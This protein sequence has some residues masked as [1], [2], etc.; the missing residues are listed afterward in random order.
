M[1][2]PNS[3]ASQFTSSVYV[4]KISRFPVPARCKS[5][6]HFCSSSV[7]PEAATY[8]SKSAFNLS[9]RCAKIAGSPMQSKGEIHGKPLSVTAILVAKCSVA[10][11]IKHAFNNS[12][13]FNPLLK[14]T[15][16][17]LV[18]FQIRKYQ[19]WTTLQ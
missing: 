3:L 15:F 11:S 4:L 10:G 6:A 16:L 14:M 13:D 8:S 12:T 5:K 19:I 1:A 17:S 18:H 2:L 9:Q 7:T